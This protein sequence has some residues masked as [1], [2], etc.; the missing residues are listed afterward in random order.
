MA[1]LQQQ[2]RDL[3]QQQQPQQQQ[4]QQSQ[5]LQQSSSSSSSSSHPTGLGPGLSPGQGLAQGPEL[6]S[7][8]GLSAIQYL[9]KPDEQP[10]EQDDQRIDMWFAIGMKVYATL[11]THALNDRLGWREVEKSL[12]LYESSSSEGV[13]SQSVKGGTMCSL[14]PKRLVFGFCW[15]CSSCTH[16]RI[17]HSFTHSR[18]HPSPHVPPHPSPPHLPI[19]Y[20]TAII[21]LFLRYRRWVLL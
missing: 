16:L 9:L 17:H 1:M 11:L 21:D 4:Q 3:I 12:S 8:P 10:M 5:P 14:P 7:E 20:S 13:Q 15:C 18:S 6:A 2:L 19:I